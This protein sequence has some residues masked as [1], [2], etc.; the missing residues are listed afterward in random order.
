MSETSFVYLVGVVDGCYKIGF[1]NDPEARLSSYA[2]LLPVA[3][4]IHHRIATTRPRWLENTLHSAFSHRRV[5]GE[6]FR[7]EP[8]DIGIIKNLLRVDSPEDIPADL[9]ALFQSHKAEVPAAFDEDS[10]IRKPQADGKPVKP[11]AKPKPGRRR[12]STTPAVIVREQEL[13]YLGTIGDETELLPEESG[14][15]MTLPELTRAD[16]FPLVLYKA[17][18]R[19]PSIYPKGARLI[20][21]RGGPLCKMDTVAFPV[22]GNNGPGYDLMEVVVG[23]KGLFTLVPMD[24][25]SSLYPINVGY[26][27]ALPRFIDAHG[28]GVMVALDLSR[29]THPEPSPSDPK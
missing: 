17:M 28:Y 9:L 22:W 15:T 29:A 7:L 5:R 19:C 4:S 24:E 2:P 1:A 13:P 14:Y 25:E 26:N 12:K 27:P 16:Y 21:R 23:E 10:P 3:P 20:C 18:S 8:A 6:W 11:T